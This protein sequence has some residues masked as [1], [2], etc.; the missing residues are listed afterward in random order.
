[1]AALADLYEYPDLGFVF[2]RLRISQDNNFCNVCNNSTNGFFR[3][4]F[5]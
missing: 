5:L 4:L 1:M 3:V 2:P